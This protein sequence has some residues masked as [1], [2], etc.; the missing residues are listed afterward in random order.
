M[1]LT[2]QDLRHLLAD[3]SAAAPSA[4]D[5]L[6]QVQRRVRRR[7]VWVAMASAAAALVVA[8][9]AFA[10]NRPTQVG[11]TNT[12]PP[13]STTSTQAG[14]HFEGRYLVPTTTAVLP[15]WIASAADSYYHGGYHYD[16]TNGDRAI[17]LF[18]VTSMYPLGATKVTHPSYAALV[19]DWKAIQTAG[20]GT[21]S[22]VVATTVDGKPATR[23]TVHVSKDY[24]GGFALC[25]GTGLPPNGDACAGLFHDRLMYVAIVDQG[26]TYP[27]TLLWESQSS[28]S[29]TPDTA[30]PSAAAEFATW[31]ATVQFH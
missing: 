27:P 5:R 26:R 31:L 24:P 28:S 13:T 22:D 29:A 19:E 4:P 23:M 2:E 3:R 16:Q 20:Y 17:N 18:V 11:S 8:G 6:A 12:P 9:I 21:V 30:S 1:S 25:R 7:H 10:V 15:H 14:F